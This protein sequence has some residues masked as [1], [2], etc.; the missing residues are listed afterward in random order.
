MGLKWG[1]IFPLIAIFIIIIGIGG[2]LIFLN[3]QDILKNPNSSTQQFSIIKGDNY[4]ESTNNSNHKN[5]KNLLNPEG[6][7]SLLFIADESYRTSNYINDFKKDIL[8]HLD[9]EGDNYGLFSVD[10][11]KKFKDNFKIDYI[12]EVPSGVRCGNSINRPN[13]NEECLLPILLAT[14]LCSPDY[15]I[16]LVKNG[17]SGKA[18]ANNWVGYKNMS[19]IINAAVSSSCS[20]NKNLF[21]EDYNM[22]NK[23]F[24]CPFIHP[25]SQATMTVHEFSH[26]FGLHDMYGRLKKIEGDVNLYVNQENLN[27]NCDVIGCPKWC[28]DYDESLSGIGDGNIGINCEN[29]TGCYE[30]CGAKN[31]WKPV[32]YPTIMQGNSYQDIL[33]GEP[34]R[35]DP[36]SYQAIYE[37]LST[38][39]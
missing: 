32:N 16:V 39:E 25:I 18:Y 4:L 11:Y 21:P 6:E 10:P 37:K 13:Q 17:L 24:G 23:E 34:Y 1:L 14:K 3:K 2:Y 35:F 22:I 29:N 8:Y 9:L 28:E 19:G 38:F 33:D 12:T 30:M 5:C 15:V 31:L 7:I 20:S 26:L 27:Q 36:I